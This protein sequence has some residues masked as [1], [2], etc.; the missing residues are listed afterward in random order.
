MSRIWQ[1]LN[2]SLIHYS[3][4]VYS[5]CCII[6]SNR[7]KDHPSFCLSLI[8]V[9]VWFIVYTHTHT[10]SLTSTIYDCHLIWFSGR[11]CRDSNYIIAFLL[12][13]HFPRVF[14]PL[15]SPYSRTFPVLP[16][17]QIVYIIKGASYS[18]GNNR[19]VQEALQ[20][21]KTRPIKRRMMAPRRARRRKGRFEVS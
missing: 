11:R 19:R 9:R 3:L 18:S 15:S 2:I 8:Y 4:C 12:Y 20:Q 7:D 16:Y 17:H 5:C 6:K 13:E 14:V 1:N 21:Q 10:R